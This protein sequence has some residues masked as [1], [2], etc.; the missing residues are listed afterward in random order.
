MVIISHRHFYHS[1][2][3][4]S[5]PKSV[6]FPSRAD[7]LQSKKR[8]RM[9]KKERKRI[10]Y[11]F[12]SLVFTVE[13]FFE[14]R[15]KIKINKK[16]CTKKRY[17]ISLS[18]SLTHILDILRDVERWTRQNIIKLYISFRLLWK[19]FANILFFYFFRCSFFRFVFSFLSCLSNEIDLR[20]FRKNEQKRERK[21]ET[22]RVKNPFIIM[23][24]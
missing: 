8:K 14:R 16:L 9:G 2:R 15:S 21:K 17:A 5:Q 7:D 23:A 20:W 4:H 10:R 11:L 1:K 3:K 6:V 12:L 18:L 13:L 19:W 22:K 24:Q